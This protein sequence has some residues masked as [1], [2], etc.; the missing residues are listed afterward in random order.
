MRRHSLGSVALLSVFL[1]LAPKMPA[2]AAA[3]PHPLDP[4]SP[5]ELQ[6]AA[7]IMRAHPAFPKDGLFPLLDLKEPTKDELASFEAGTPLDRKT[8]ATILDRA[9]NRT[10]EAVA[11]LTTGKILSWKLVSGVNPMIMMEEYDQATNLVRADARWQAAM[12]RRG[13]TDFKQVAIDGWASGPYVGKAN[14]KVSGHRL[15]RGLSFL[16]GTNV[17]YY[18]R[19]IEGVLALI[20]L[21]DQKVVELSDTGLIP[22]AAKGHDFDEASLAPLRPAPASMSI[23]MPAGTGATVTGQQVEW[24]KWRFRFAFHP[25]EGLVLYNIAYHDHDRWR[26]ILNRVALGEMIVPYGDP[27]PNWSWRSAFDVGEY[28][29]GKLSS[30]LDLGQD[31]PDTGQLFDAVFADS[32]GKPYTLPRAVGLYERDGG[33]LWKHYDFETGTNSV[34]RARQLVITSTAAIGNYDYLIS[35][36]FGQDGAI[37]VDTALTG[38]LLAKGTDQDKEEVETCPG[39]TT[40]LLEPHISAPN[41]E[42]FF[43]FRL[44]FDIDGARNSVS[45]MNCASIPRGAAN[46]SGTGWQMSETLL[47]HERTAQRDLNPT[48]ARRWRVFNPS[49]RNAWGQTTGYMLMPTETATPYAVSG[50][51]PRKRAA[52]LD[53]DLW[54]TRYRP[55]QLYSAGPYPN[56]STSDHGLS[57]WTKENAS[58]TNQDIVMWYTF[59]VTHP[60]RTEDWPMMP[61]YH[62][63]FKLVPAG[64]FDQSPAMDVPK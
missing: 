14:P 10:Y 55:D 16:K 57:L 63:G 46:P 48:T 38:I 29:F 12:R 22:V 19:P 6:A 5:D 36:I 17:S 52:F 31:I 59:G 61:A 56:Q 53:H 21:T 27:D 24:Q 35:W 25:R 64:F 42:H 11:D 15:M 33:V 8:F 32:T 23:V 40:H 50:S 45:E 54:I 3:P 41:H 49:V 28:G 30:P 18:G 4:L 2:F 9:K 58:I 1:A 26:P 62:T 43:N 44:D 47:T 7:A 20:D 13:I 37:E 39:C 34:R 60:P 51:L